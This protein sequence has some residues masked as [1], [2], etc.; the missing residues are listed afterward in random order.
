MKKLSSLSVAT[1]F[2]TGVFAQTVTDGLRALDND[3]LIKAK[4]TFQSLLGSKP[5]EAT[6]AYYQLASLYMDQKTTDSAELVVN[7]MQTAYPTNAMSKVAAGKLNLYKKNATA[8]KISFDEALKISANKD[9]K[10]MA[11]I[12]D[13]YL[14]TENTDGAAA[15]QVL[16]NA[17]KLDPKNAELYLLTGD[18]HKL[19]L[20][21]GGPAI[22]NYEKAIELNAQLVKANQRIGLVYSQA[23]N[24]QSSSEYFEKSLGMDANYAPTLRD[25]A[26]LNY[27]FKQYEK[28]RAL[29]EKY[30]AIAD[31]TELTL[32]RYVYILFMCKDYPAATA[33]INTLMVRD[34]NN[35]LLNR[36]LAYSYAEQ[37]QDS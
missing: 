19:D 2:A 1:L 10:V 31:T 36:L 13:A 9:A 6:I 3:Q 5:E 34:A 32:T 30:L 28:S 17:T 15:L 4:N 7:R 21:S 29:Y 23:R 35:N 22:T 24:Y 37:K 26:M 14:T 8:A 16:A 11:W 25:Y 20:N 12:A 33:M 18:A 27:N